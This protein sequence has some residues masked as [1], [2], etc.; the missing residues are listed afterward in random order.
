MNKIE[1]KLKLI[2]KIRNQNTESQT[3][4]IKKY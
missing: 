3:L 2:N 4:N 1:N